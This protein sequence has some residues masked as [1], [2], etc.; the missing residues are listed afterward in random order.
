[1]Q[2]SVR[3][4]TNTGFRNTLKKAAQ[5]YAN[6]LMHINLV[7]NLYLTIY[8]V[9]KNKEYP[10]NGSCEWTDR[11]YNPREFAIY[12][13]EKLSK[14]GKLQTLAHEMV[15]LKQYAK[16]EMD[17][18][19]HATGIVKW[20]GVKFKLNS[21]MAPAHRKNGKLKIQSAGADYY[22]LPW[23]VEAYGLEVGL[24]TYFRHKFGVR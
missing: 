19:D 23:E 2:V 20:K 14:T 24:S 6:E 21:K 1:M 18:L 5:F 15:H 4:E 9:K 12:I 22:Y 13:T 7:K 10:D 17:G 16:N 8:I 11:S 3:G